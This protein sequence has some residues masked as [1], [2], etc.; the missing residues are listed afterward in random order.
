MLDENPNTQAESEAETQNASSEN[1]YNRGNY[2]FI[3]SFTQLHPAGSVDQLQLE[4][5]LE[6]QLVF[7]PP[8]SPRG[9]P[10][11]ALLRGLK[12]ATLAGGGGL[13]WPPSFKDCREPL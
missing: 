4:V 12:R 5:E 10:L 13:T 9:P 3:G 8:P 7:P 11:A 2:L 1:R 6:I